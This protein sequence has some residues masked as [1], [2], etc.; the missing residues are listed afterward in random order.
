M[1]LS[2]VKPYVMKKQY[3]DYIT[4]MLLIVQNL[5][6]MRSSA[7]ILD[8]QYQDILNMMTDVTY[9]L[10]KILLNQ[11]MSKLCEAMRDFMTD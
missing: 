8:N 7:Q 2:D 5:W 9:G 3:E 4:T 1:K 6:S 11:S 10:S